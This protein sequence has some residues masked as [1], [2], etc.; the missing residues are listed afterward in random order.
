MV[1]TTKRPLDN[2]LSISCF[3]M[4]NRM[5]QFPL[6]S[7]RLLGDIERRVDEVFAE[8]IH[9]PWRSP[10]AVLGWEPAVDIHETG[11]EYTVL[12]DLPGVGPG[13]VNVSIEDQT[14]VVHGTRSSQKWA[15]S[16]AMIY[17]E[18]FQGEFVRR[19]PLPGP[20]DPAGLDVRSSQGLLLIQLP[21][22]KVR[23]TGPQSAGDRA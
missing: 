15:E 19:I 17:T 9:G 7:I 18:R 20:V 16:G 6:K 13:E 10:S 5:S 8:L 23:T 14:L 3:R 2:T 11:N 4:H 1:G 22:M 12:V 21:K